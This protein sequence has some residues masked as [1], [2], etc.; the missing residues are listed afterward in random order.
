MFLS[1]RLR[2]RFR[3][4]RKPWWITKKYININ[5]RNRIYKYKMMR[6]KIKKTIPSINRN[7]N[8]NFWKIRRL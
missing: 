4:T 2:K 6:I 5:T 3:K 7:F 8:K 1:T